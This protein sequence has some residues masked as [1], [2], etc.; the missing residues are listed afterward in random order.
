M[1]QRSGKRAHQNHTFGGRSRN[2][3]G[4]RGSR[5]G[6]ELCRGVEGAGFGLKSFL[7]PRPARLDD[8]CSTCNSMCGS[9]SIHAVRQYRAVDSMIASFTSRSSSHCRNWRRIAGGCAKA[10]ALNAARG[11]PRGHIQHHHHENFP[12]HIDSCSRVSHRFLPVWKRRNSRHKNLT[13]RHA[14]PPLPPEAVAPRSSL[15]T[16][17]PNHP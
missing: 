16:R 7:R 13:H 14:L 10:P 4:T 5:P 1:H 2:H 3:V 9:D 12:V 17:V 8:A 11:L 6:D 15:Q